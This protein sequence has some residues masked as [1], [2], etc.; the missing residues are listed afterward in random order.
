MYENNEEENTSTFISRQVGSLGSQRF[1]QEM[2]S[3]HLIQNQRSV[4]RWWP[5]ACVLQW[6]IWKVS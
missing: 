2:Q 3:M 4:F 1:E 5:V 6:K